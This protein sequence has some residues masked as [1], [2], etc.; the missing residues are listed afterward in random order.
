MLRARWLYVQLLK[1]Y[2]S[3]IR[4]IFDFRHENCELRLRT[5]LTIMLS[6][7]RMLNIIR[8][9][10]DAANKD[11]SVLSNNLANAQTVGFKR[12]QAVFEDQ[13]SQ[14]IEERAA[15]FTGYGTK[16]L[17][18]RQNHAQGALRATKAALDM[19]VIGQGYFMMGA[20]AEPG[21][22]IYS[23]DGAF[24][25]AKDGTI[26]NSLG[27]PLLDVKGKTMRIPLSVTTPEDGR[28]LL[29]EVQVTPAG[30][31][32]AKYGPNMKLDV[33]Q[34]GLARFVNQ[35]GLRQRGLSQ[36]VE[37]DVSGVP[38]FGSASQ[39]GFGTIS[40]GNLEMAN[41]DV[42]GELTSILLAQQSFSGMSRVL[43]T[44]SDMVKRFSQK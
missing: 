8:S 33:G 1:Q 30:F 28:R 14:A 18:P 39:L 43:Q 6:E 32:E 38:K 5:S 35:A 15:H 44:D 13:Y 26:T 34:I 29:D 9:G 42:S 21:E 17:M 3:H 31:I 10:L 23:R 11:I 16:T 40:N 36:F 27:Q 22:I 4:F 20:P 24:Q 25:L 41:T 19:A 7:A 37:S 2:F 12:S